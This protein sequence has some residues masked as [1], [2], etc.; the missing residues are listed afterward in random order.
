MG[1]DAVEITYE[2]TGIQCQL[3]RWVRLSHAL[4]SVITEDNLGLCLG[5]SVA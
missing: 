2:G 5:Y 1:W 4:T 3:L